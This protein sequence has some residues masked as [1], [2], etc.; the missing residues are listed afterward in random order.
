MDILN[1]LFLMMAYTA[2]V[3]FFLFGIDD[4]FFDL[5]IL[6]RLRGRRG[7]PPVPIET[8]RNEP[9]K[10]IAIFIPAWN[11]GGIVNRMA[12][13]ARK[14]LL[15]ENYD[16]F[17]GVYAN[18]P[19]T[20]RCVDE[21]VKISPR[22]HKAVVPHAGPTSKADCLNYIFNTM[23]ACEIPGRREYAII[24]L[25]DAE[26]ILHPLT[27]KV[28]NHYVPEILD[29]GQIPVFPLELPPLTNWVG[30][31]YLDEFAELHVKDMYAREAIG[32][33]VPSA[34]VGTAFSRKSL[35][36][37]AEEN[38][39]VP[40]PDGSLAEDYFVGMKLAAMGFRTGFIENPVERQ[41]VRRDAKG[42]EIS[43]KNI[44]ERVAVRENFPRRFFQAV[45]Q[46]A[47][48]IIGTAFQSWE[49]QGWKGGLAAK[50]TLVR[51]RR[52]PVVHTINAAG[53]CAVAYMIADIGIRH[54]V[55]ANS[56]YLPPLFE[57]NGL[58]WKLVLVDTALLCYRV[59]QKVYH[60]TDV[61]GWKQGIFSIPRYPVVNFIN[62]G[63]T[64][65]AIVVYSRHRLLG[66]PLA[67]AKT[68][69]TFPGSA[70]L[71]E[72]NRSVE[73][74]LI[75]EGYVLRNDLEN[76]LVKNRDRS[77][78]R[79]LLEMGLIDEGQF[80]DIWSKHS[81]LDVGDVDVA[82]IDLSLLDSWPEKKALRHEAMPL[83][84][85]DDGRTVFA[86]AEPPTERDLNRVVE[87][88]GTPVEPV[89]TAPTQITNLRNH[90]Y[91]RRILKPRAF[92]LL[93]PESPTALVNAAP[94]ISIIRALGPFFCELHGLLPMLDGSIAAR[95]PVHP[96]I[97]ARMHK[98]LGTEAP[99]VSD[100][101]R[102]FQTA[103]RKFE[104]LRMPHSS[105]LQELAEAEILTKENTER[106]QNMARL[107]ST[108]M[109]RM[110]VQLGLANRKQVYNALR[111]CGGVDVAADHD[112]QVARGCEDLLA[113]GFSAKT[114]V[115][116]HHLDGDGLVMRL[117]GMLSPSELREIFDRCEGWPLRFELLA[118]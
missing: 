31:T 115:V 25:H 11:E 21:L 72:F 14:T 35:D 105:L 6:R 53:Y 18:D 90:A 22:V 54:T 117:S 88:A 48:W 10:L 95:S 51:D 1:S 66:K 104:R 111:R 81:G 87:T 91:P 12:D 58:L 77:A 113:P 71:G 82:I 7:E 26:D 13:Y 44:T 61:Y 84:R 4:L 118:P 23:R 65:W 2:A 101:T 103:W 62:M 70:E 29:M 38:N 63:A 86:F 36:Q 9:E 74:L 28:Y 97:A 93:L 96:G 45:R 99:L 60:V 19:E 8:L 75:D 59:G 52:A 43:R 110:L 55:L 42:R 67:W 85:R 116:V 24:A 79:A 69:H 73:D 92:P 3:G 83:Q 17:I 94:S 32:G 46:K 106:I 15:Y 107:V 50:Y 56:F 102:G 114:G 30:N 40:F 49:H 33:V 78:P 34:G 57:A 112:H 109:D 64:F 80:C 41:V 27:L 16:L 68:T 20:N 37:L 98:I 76:I 100:K 108:P 89:L 5:Q 47:R 39:G